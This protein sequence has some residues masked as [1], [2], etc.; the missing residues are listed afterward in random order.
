MSEKQDQSR[1]EAYYNII[2]RDGEV[3]LMNDVDDPRG[4]NF[5]D[6]YHEGLSDLLSSSEGAEVDADCTNVD[7]QMM[8]MVFK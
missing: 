7:D 6:I 1:W 4:Q 5:K 3:E 2:D 8:R